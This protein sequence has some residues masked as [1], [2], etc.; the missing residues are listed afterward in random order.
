MTARYA[1]NYQR[2]FRL[3]RVIDGDSCVAETDLAFGIYSHHELRYLGLNCPEAH[4]PGGPEATAFAVAWY[5]EHAI[6]LAANQDPSWPFFLR[7][8]KRDVEKF[9]RY[10][11]LVT[12]GQNHSL[13]DE[14]IASGNAVPYL[15]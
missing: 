10:L 14:L 6:H 7:S 11:C 15:I 13:N 1:D 12:C 5:A 3:M 2:R 8:V 9:G 4:T